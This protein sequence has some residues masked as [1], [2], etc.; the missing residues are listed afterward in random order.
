MENCLRV[1]GDNPGWLFSTK[2]PLNKFYIMTKGK[3]RGNYN[4]PFRWMFEQL[5]PADDVH[6]I[7]E[8]TYEEMLNGQ[9]FYINHDCRGVITKYHPVNMGKDDED[10]EFASSILVFIP[11][12]RFAAL[13]EDQLTDDEKAKGFKKNETVAVKVG[14]DWSRN[15]DTSFIYYNEKYAPYFLFNNVY[16][17]VEDVIDS[18]TKEE[19]GE[20]YARVLLS[21]NSEIDRV[22]ESTN[23]IEKYR[24]YRINEDGEKE[25]VDVNDLIVYEDG[26]ETEL[27]ASDGTIRHLNGAMKIYVKEKKEKHGRQVEYL[28]EGSVAGANI[29]YV[30]SNISLASIPGYDIAERCE[31]ILVEDPS[32]VFIHKDVDN[33]DDSSTLTYKEADY[34]HYRHAFGLTNDVDYDHPLRALHLTRAEGETEDRYFTLMRTDSLK[35]AETDEA[36]W[37]EVERLTITRIAEDGDYYVYYGQTSGTNYEGEKFINDEKA[38]FRSL[39]ADGQDAV[40]DIATEKGTV[41]FESIF[42][43]NTKDNL[44]PNKYYYQLSS[45]IPVR[46]EGSSVTAE[47]RVIRIDIPHTYTTASLTP[48]TKAE[49]MDDYDHTLPLSHKEI[50]YYIKQDVMVRKYDLDLYHKRGEAVHNLATVKRAQDGTHSKSERDFTQS[51][52]PTT[53]DTQLVYTYI[54]SE[55]D[56]TDS[57]E[58]FELHRGFGDEIDDLYAH[59]V[60]VIQDANK[61][62]Y[63]TGRAYLGKKPSFKGEVNEVIETSPGTYQVKARIT[64]CPSIVDDHADASDHITPEQYYRTTVVTDFN[65]YLVNVYDEDFWNR[66]D[67]IVMHE[68]VAFNDLMTFS[69][70]DVTW[71]ADMTYSFTPTWTVGTF[72]EEE[73]NEKYPTF[74][75]KQAVTTPV[76][77]EEYPL[78]VS[79]K[80]RNYSR[81]ASSTDDNPLYAVCEE[82]LSIGTNGSEIT[83]GVDNPELAAQV[84]VDIYSVNGTLV[85]S[86]VADRNAPADLHGL[87][88]GVYILRVECKAYK[89]M[90]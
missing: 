63:G 34:N 76:D 27:R 83:V 67:A 5:S 71:D 80:V 47:S 28:V 79:V 89:I 84:P 40:A 16:L 30:E 90:R 32:S 15:G 77:G 44:H 31:L 36:E 25:L 69:V 41:W 72:S 38:Y 68:P 52:D 22:L 13:E 18:E 53:G 73:W 10:E 58:N 87:P 29:A 39:I 17:T 88:S 9:K 57:I 21:W 43:A 42:D 51:I 61:N 65:P 54:N 74:A 45:N 78:I 49:I 11:D 8:N 59:T 82:Y 46:E 1:E 37:E 62:T 60:V 48:Y 56:V 4:K 6:P 75:E 70:D 14:G 35:D 64:K 7:P 2:T 85:R 33:D 20:E 81:L 24:L 26:V 66:D 50:G 3:M 19:D 86:Y 23:E 55:Q 12:K